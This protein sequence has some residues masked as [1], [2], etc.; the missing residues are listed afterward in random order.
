MPSSFEGWPQA[1]DDSGLESCQGI[2]PN[3]MAVIVVLGN[4]YVG[5][6]HPDDDRDMNRRCGSG[7]NVECASGGGGPIQNTCIPFLVRKDGTKETSRLHDGRL[8]CRI[9]LHTH[10]PG[11]EHEL[12][13]KLHRDQ[14]V[15][16][17]VV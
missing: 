5:V 4:G 14:S 1:L 17:E 13:V 2:V 9:I 3:L 8:V 11:E 10:L 12:W 6:G 16:V 7:S 15:C